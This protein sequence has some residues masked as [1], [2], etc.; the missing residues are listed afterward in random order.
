M[1]KLTAM[2]VF[3]AV[4][5]TGAISRAAE[6]VG[7]STAV[8][9]RAITSLEKEL[10]SRL[11]HRTTRQLQVTDAGCSITGVVST[12][13]FSWTTRSRLSENRTPNPKG[14]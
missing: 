1:D 11:L 14:F 5:E 3:C 12:L 2:K 4:V 10:G 9:S 7:L 6:A 13:S 8:V